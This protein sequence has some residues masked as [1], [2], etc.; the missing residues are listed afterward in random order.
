LGEP[1]IYGLE[2]LV[3]AKTA[4]TLRNAVRVELHCSFHFYFKYPAEHQNFAVASNESNQLATSHFLN[5]K[6]LRL[7]RTKYHD[8]PFS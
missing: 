1:S 4:M 7:Q 6:Y 8:S 3:D 5:I 2:L